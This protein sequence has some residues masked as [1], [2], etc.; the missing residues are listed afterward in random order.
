M[1]VELLWR[2]GVYG[3]NR[4][5]LPDRAGLMQSG[6]SGHI[7]CE[8]GLSRL[9]H[10]VGALI[11]PD[12]TG[13]LI[14]IEPTKRKAVGDAI[15]AAEYKL[16]L[17]AIEHPD[18]LGGSMGDIS[19]AWAEYPILMISVLRLDNKWSEFW[20]VHGYVGLSA[21]AYRRGHPNW[22]KLKAYLMPPIPLPLGVKQ[23]HRKRT[24]LDKYLF[25][26]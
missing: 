26:E 2:G 5:E 19:F 10:I 11:P 14:C 1:K 7:G 9:R 4:D 15:V 17:H 25:E 22:A 16:W 21:L 18:S 24:M 12:E 6:L 20:A 23:Y 13:D 8:R 3:V